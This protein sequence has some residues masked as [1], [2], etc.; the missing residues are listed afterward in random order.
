MEKYFTLSKRWIVLFMIPIFGFA[1]AQQNV[2]GK[3]TDSADGSGIPGVNVLVK[4][5]TTGTVTD[6]DGNFKLE[7]SD[8][9]TVLVFS[10]IGYVTQEV[11]VGDRSVIDIQLATDAKQLDEIVVVGYGTQK[12]KEVTGAVGSLGSETILKTPTADLGSAI[13]GQIAGVNVQAANGRPGE[14]ANI[15]IR[16]L[17][18]IDADRL[19]PLYVVDGIPYQGNPNIAPEQIESIDVLKDGAS[20]AIYGTRA[21]GGVILITTKAGKAGELKV[22]FTS[23]AGIQNITSGTPLNNTQQQMYV[24]DV[25]LDAVGQEPLIFTFNPDA[26]DY[27]SD[28]VGD[29][30]N[31]NAVMQSYNLLVSGGEDNLTFSINTN[32]FGQDG[33]LI[34]SGY[35]RFSTRLNGQF[36]TKK[37]RAFASMGITNERRE[38]EP[39]A[40]YEYA[41]VQPPWQRGLS[42]LDP[43]GSNGVFVPTRNA[44]QYGWLARQLQ[45][46]D[47]RTTNGY[48]LALN[49]EY[50]FVD[51]LSYQVNLGLNESNYRRKE[52]VPQFLTYGLNGLEPAGSNMDATIDETFRLN[53]GQVWENLLKYNKSFGAHSI[54]AVAGLT[55]ERYTE[56]LVTAGVSTLL[57]ND[58]KVLGAGVSARV[59]G[60]DSERTLVGKLF[61]LQYS[62]NEKY[63]VSVSVRHD[64]SSAF[65]DD[66]RYA[67]FPGASVGWNISEEGFFKNAGALSFISNMKLR[68]S[69]GQVGNQNIGLYLDQNTIQNGVDYVFGTGADESLASGAV[70]RGF[71]NPLVQWETSISRNIGV[72]MS[73]FA[74]R[75]N[76]SVD[77]YKND[78]QDMLLPQALAPSNGTSPTRSE[79]LYSSVV[80]NG[81]NMENKGIEVALNYRN[82]TAFG[83]KWNI[84]GTFT[85][86]INKV[87]DLNGIEGFAFSGG[88]PILSR[89]DRIDYT[90]FLIEGY[91]AGAFFLVQN[92]GV[93]K[94]AEQ[95][96]DY[97][98]INPNAMMGDIMYTDQLT[99]DTD[100]DGVPDAGDNVINDLDRVYSGSGQADF[101]AGL[102]LGA[103]FKGFDLFVQTYAS[104]GADLYNGSKLY[105]YST[106]RHRDMYYMWSVHNSD[107]DIPTARTNQ[108]HSN[109][110]AFSDYYLEDGS[111]LRIRNITLGYSLPQSLLNGKL[112]SVRVY[113]TAQNPFTFTKYEGYD[114]EIGGDGIYTRGVDVGNYPITRNFLLGLQVK[115]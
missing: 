94:T 45:N 101:E 38:Q 16:G 17:S 23:Y 20:A 100:G 82:E 110:R 85:K 71:A 30:Q 3:V 78:R 104:V 54:S 18:S 59:G 114:P 62:F 113:A 103:D 80:V 115:F 15:Q 86:N 48:N 95:L 26:L 111:Y 74:D 52:F 35:D 84:A 43:V 91:E 92:E 41:I 21:S 108:E 37:F 25:R 57:S 2:G 112:T 12:K 7:V 28:F 106:G 72:D 61:R 42:D 67:T 36:K 66:S 13:Q 90:T 56:N 40:L 22:D 81:G 29:V 98:A 4:G 99:V 11:S 53:Q 44:V 70:Q 27:D 24:E 75:L 51:G 1:E 87:T 77:L 55:Y 5:T 39:W 97:Q 60:S 109:T 58:T 93:I 96:A 68:G 64:G 105:A 79:N 32:Y 9:N 10:Y 65:G 50:E 6:L 19:G 73:M 46:E 47:D 88:R 14:T 8:S 69:Y 107:S 31:D 83:L 34:N 89:G 49:L 33:V 63:M 102:S 76:L